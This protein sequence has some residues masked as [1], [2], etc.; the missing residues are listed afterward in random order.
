MAT[1]SEQQISRR[2]RDKCAFPVVTGVKIPAGTMFFITTAGFATNVIAAGANIFGGVA[3]KTA[4]NTSGASGDVWVEGYREGLFRMAASGLAQTNVPDK[5][6]AV[7]NNT[8]SL[9]STN[10]TYVGTI[11]EYVSATECI[12]DAD[13][14]NQS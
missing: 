12:F 1:T 9:T 10:Q 6:Y 2:D 5:V 3:Y 14:F 8:L 13:T 11:A 4:D 7:D